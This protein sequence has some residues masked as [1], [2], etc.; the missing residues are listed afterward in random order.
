MNFFRKLIFI[1]NSKQFST[2][3][4]RE[5]YAIKDYSYLKKAFLQAPNFLKIQ[6]AEYLGY[7]EDQDNLDFLIRQF[8]CTSDMKLRSYTYYSILNIAKNESLQISEDDKQLL[9]NNI[10]LL[11]NIGFVNRQQKDKAELG[12]ITFRDKLKDHLK[13]LDDKKKLN[14]RMTGF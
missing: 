14:E 2:T 7:F 6:A 4:L 5:R 11:E 9:Y 12:A 13:V 1:L 8:K 3:K 10:D